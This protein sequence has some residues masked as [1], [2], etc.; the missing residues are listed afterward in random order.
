MYIKSIVVYLN[1]SNK[2]NDIKT[3]NE[4][5]AKSEISEIF[6][7]VSFRKFGNA[8]RKHINEH[9]KAEYNL[10]SDG[11]LVC[12]SFIWSDVASYIIGDGSYGLTEKQHNGFM[13]EFE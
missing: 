6:N 10:K 1:M 12:A 3:F 11:G 5:V 8:F 13:K 2:Q 9:F 4:S 7:R